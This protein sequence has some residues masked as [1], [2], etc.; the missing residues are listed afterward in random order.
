[1]SIVVAPTAAAAGAQDVPEKALLFIAA[2]R[3]AAADGL[4]WSEF[5]E[6]LFS[7]VHLCVESL[8]SVSNLDGP[9]KKAFA[10]DAVG[11]LFDA[12]AD[13]AVPVWVWPVWPFA[14]PAIRALLVSL[15]SGAVEQFIPLVRASA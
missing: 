11:R 5:S 7:L 9:S 3:A 8:D 14:R 4:T 12:V 1:M 6:L 13:R 10:L 2:A 15:A